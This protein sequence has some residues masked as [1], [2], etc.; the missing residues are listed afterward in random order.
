MDYTGERPLDPLT[1]DL[2][3]GDGTFTLYEDDGQ[4]FQYELGQFSTTSYVLRRMADQLV[5]EIGAREGE[6]IPPARRLVIRVHAVGEQ[7]AEGYP[8]TSYDP[9]RRQLTLQ[10]DDNGQ[11]RTFHFKLPLA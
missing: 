5:L 9:E 2:Y 10:L 7:A 8:D 6:F 4:S 11:E 3:P 1:L